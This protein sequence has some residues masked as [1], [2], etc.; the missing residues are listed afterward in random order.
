M[1]DEIF[2]D[3]STQIKI[4]LIKQSI[5]ILNLNIKEKFQINDYKKSNMLNGFDDIDYLINM[6]DSI[7]KFEKN[8]PL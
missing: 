7:Q 8:T 2:K 5:E 1:F 3:P 6:K 4:N